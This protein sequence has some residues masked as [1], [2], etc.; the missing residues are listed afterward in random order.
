M[1]N[2]IVMLLVGP[3]VALAVSGAHAAKDG[4]LWEMSMQRAEGNGP[5]GATEVTKLCFGKDK[6]F[7][8][9]PE[10]DDPNCKH[11]YK[12]SGKRTTFKSVCKDADGSITSSGVSEEVGPYHYK[13]DVTIVQEM[14]GEPRMQQRQ[15]G[16]MKRIGS[17]CD[18]NEM[19]ER[20]KSMG[21]KG[22]GAPSYDAPASSGK[23]A[24]QPAPAARSGSAPKV[25]VESEPAASEPKEP[26]AKSPAE[27]E[28][29]Q[30]PSGG[31]VVDGAVEAG[32]SILKGI[33]KF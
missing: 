30:A 10:K 21:P 8:E 13:S 11:D 1:R 28:P 4:E 6:N 25:A 20:F 32:K 2:K 15:V 16:T 17:A 19:F 27:K 24:K 3:C 14:R 33:L 22:G 29:A 7:K 18:P 9:P 26:M 12:T 5:L 31:S 23:S